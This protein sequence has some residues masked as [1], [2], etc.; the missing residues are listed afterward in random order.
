MLQIAVADSSGV[1]QVF[2]IKKRE[3]QASGVVS[4]FILAYSLVEALV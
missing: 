4:T 3:V 2:G 1:V